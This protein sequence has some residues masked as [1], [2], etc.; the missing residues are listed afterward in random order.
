MGERLRALYVGKHGVRAGWRILLW[1][2]LF[3]ALGVVSGAGVRAAPTEAREWLSILSALG[4]ALAAGWIVLVAVD[5]RPPGA[6]GFPL[7]REV[8][9]E[10]LWGFALGG[11]AIGLTTAMIVVTGGA[12]WVPDTGG[13][14][15][16]VR[17]L[18]AALGFFA[19]A[20]AVEEVIFRGYPFQALVEG[21]GAWPATLLASVGFSLLHAENPGIGRL[22]FVNIFLAGVLL[23]V[24]YL[25]TRSLWF[26]TALH[27]GWNWTMAALLDFPVSGLMRDTPLYDAVERGPEW[28]TG[29]AFGP[30]AG[31][32][33]TAVLVG[34][35]VWFA[36]SS[37]LAVHSTPVRENDED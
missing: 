12:R 14:A 10:A 19:L 29:G 4:A 3:V 36:R 37:R 17:V 35:T 2:L 27:L 34:A 9:R 31:F 21:I 26:V 22:A 25:R 11:G 15:E 20:A 1:V 33:A 8:P 28:W 13:A 18:V 7:H 30:E 32:A 24:A 5:G 16:Y 23:S 6:L